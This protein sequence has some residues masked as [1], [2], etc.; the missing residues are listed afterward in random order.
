MPHELSTYLLPTSLALQYT[1][2]PYHHPVL[3]E[4][5]HCRF[6]ERRTEAEYS[7][8]PKTGRTFEQPIFSPSSGNLTVTA[9]S[10]DDGGGLSAASQDGPHFERP[11][12]APSFLRFQDPRADLGPSSPGQIQEAKRPRA[13]AAPT[14]RESR[15]K[16]PQDSKIQESRRQNAVAIRPTITP[17]FQG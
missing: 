7:S 9:S 16:K 1:C 12:K 5:Y 10:C 4:L 13:K 8:H 17:N 2:L 6:F 11:I 15:R 3:R 14:A